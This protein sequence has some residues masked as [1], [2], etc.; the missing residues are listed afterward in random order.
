MFRFTTRARLALPVAVLAATAIAGAASA[1]A[2][3]AKGTAKSLLTSAI[4]LDAGAETIT[5]PLHAGTTA[6]GARTW[7]VVIDSS[8]KADAARRGVNFAP[9]LANALGTRAVQHARSKNG[10]VAFAGTVN[11]APKRT[12]VASDEGFPPAKAVPGAVGDASY[13]PLVTLGGGVVLDAPQVMNATGRSDSV[14]SIDTARKRVTLKLL[15]GWFA[16]T[17][18][19]YV[20]TDASSTLVAALEG[21]TYAPNLDHAPGLGSDATSSA[22]SAI[23]PVINGARSGASRQGLQSAVLSGA[24]PLNITQSLPGAPD[25]TPVWDLHPAVWTTAA[26]DAGKRVELTSAAQVSADFKAGLLTSAGKGP[27]NASLGG[28]RAIS[29]ISICSTVAIG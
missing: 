17:R 10:T 4:S 13:S 22:R 2:T 1:G 20:R 7:Y 19:L 16:G 9:R 27:A 24:D 14:V 5:L 26:I 6:T 11:F 23:I 8:S 15:R 12:V 18:V 3:P 29:F 25:Y 21:S 28:L